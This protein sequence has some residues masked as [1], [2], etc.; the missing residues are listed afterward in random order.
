[1]AKHEFCIMQETPKKGVCYDKYEPQ[2]Y[3]CISANDDYMEDIVV[4]FMD[5]DFY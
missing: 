4:K 2:R 1:M 5:I 3:N